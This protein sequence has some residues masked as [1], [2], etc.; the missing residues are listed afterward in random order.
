MIMWREK[1]FAFSVHFVV[2][3]AV[4]LVA[5]AIIFLIWY[6]SPFGRMLGGTQLFLLVSGCDLALGPLLSL[7]IYNSRKSRRELITDYTVVGI[8]QLAALVYGM[9]VVAVARPAYLVFSKDRIE[10][11]TAQTIEAADL[12]EAKLEQYRRTPWLGPEFV[13][14][15]VPQSES[16]DALFKGLEGKDISARPRFYVPYES[17]LP[18]V[19][20]AL[21]P[22][23]SLTERFP[24]AAQEVESA[25]Q[26]QGI[27]AEQAGWLP[28]QH[29]RAFWTALVD[30]RTGYPF[31]YLPI[32]AF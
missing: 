16:S 32:D 17:Q 21:R 13:A 4:A 23:A 1:L 28:V 30:T 12:A 22:I 19:K 6:P 15:L 7:V 9:Y 5:A 10:V 18:E 24:A 3:L 27:V 8:V 11:I 2:T 20:S 31:Y 26:K 14:A 25:L 29:R